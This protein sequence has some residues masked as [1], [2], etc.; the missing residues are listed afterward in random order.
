MDGDG[1]GNTGGNGTDSGNS[2]W[3]DDNSGTLWGW[4]S[5]VVGGLETVWQAVINLPQLIADKL[6]VLFNNIKD[7]IVSLPQTILDG[8]K[9]I[10]IPDTEVIKEK[11]LGF[12]EDFGTIFGANFD[13]FD[14]LFTAEKPLE[15]VT[16]NYAIP[17]L[18]EFNLTILEKEWVHKGV[19][20]FRPVIRGWLVLLLIIFNWN[21]TLGLIRQAMPIAPTSP[22]ET[23]SI[24][25]SESK[26]EKMGNGWIRTT[27]KSNST[28]SRK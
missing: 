23:E 3:N 19:A 28:R 10:F 17:G 18:G 1:Q 27:T 9:D 26:S 8:V 6:S 15:D 7:A 14:N 20:F 13:A 5:S 22:S 11:F 16:V 21:N 2:G 25:I 4:L 24:T 12:V